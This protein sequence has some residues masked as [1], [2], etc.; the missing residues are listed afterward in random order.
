MYVRYVCKQMLCILC[1]CVMYVCS[2]M[3][4]YMYVV[5]VSTFMCVSVCLSVCM[6]RIEMY[7]RFVCMLST[8]VMCVRRPCYVSML[9]VYA[10]GVCMC[11]CTLCVYVMLC[12][13]V[14]FCVC[15]SICAR[16]VLYLNF[17]YLWMYVMYV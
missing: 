5:Y 17:L 14:M 2:S 8:Y 11:V 4:V 6:V 12:M 9:W 7:A 13:N 16:D 3:C 10:C 1:M 15:V